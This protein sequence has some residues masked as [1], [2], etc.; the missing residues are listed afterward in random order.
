VDLD[1]VAQRTTLLIQAELK[2]RGITLVRTVGGRAVVRGDRYEIQ[3]V[4]LNLLTNAV[5]ALSELP[6]GADRTIAVETGREGDRAFVRVRDT[7]AGIPG[8]LTSRI[9][10]PFFTTKQPGQGTGLGLSISYGIIDSHGGRLAYAPGEAGGS[11]FTIQLPAHDAT[12]GTPG[13]SRR[14]LVADNDV[15][16]LRVLSALLAQDGAELQSARTGTDT[17]AM[18]AKTGYDLVIVDPT[19][20]AANESIVPALLRQRPELASR[21]ILLGE[22]GAD[23]DPR[24]A[25]LPRLA[26]PLVPRDARAVILARMQR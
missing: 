25:T 5:H 17:F 7:G 19:L 15:S 12:G 6:A 10:T 3:Q 4:L 2:L 21:M 24:A 11:V 14:I 13:S 18:A 16:V 20:S 26:K 23:S 8:A 9:F 22:D 1:D